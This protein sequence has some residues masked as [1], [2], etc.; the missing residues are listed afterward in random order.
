MS[1]GRVGV[2]A[3]YSA[4]MFIQAAGMSAWLVPL[5]PVLDAHGLGAIKPLAFATSA[6]AC[7]VSPLFFGARRWLTI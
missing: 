7:F 2:Y 3:E 5:G 6:L 1:L 4:L